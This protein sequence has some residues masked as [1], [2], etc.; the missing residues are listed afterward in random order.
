M[1]IVSFTYVD[2][3]GLYMINRRTL[4]DFIIT[5]ELNRWAGGPSY[6]EKVFCSDVLIKGSM[7]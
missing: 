7:L 5:I 2:C 6:K 1:I 4:V 3:S